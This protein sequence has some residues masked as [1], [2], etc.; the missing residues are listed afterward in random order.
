M[1]CERMRASLLAVCGIAAFQLVNG[2]GSAATD[3]IGRCK[4]VKKAKYVAAA[5]DTDGK[6]WTFNLLP[7]KIDV[8]CNSSSEQGSVSIS[9]VIR[10]SLGAAKAGLVVR[11]QLAGESKSLWV[12]KALSDINTDACGVASFT[13]NWVCPSSNKEVS[14][15][16]NSDSG[17]LTSNSIQVTIANLVIV[18]AKSASGAGAPAAGAP[19]AGAPAA[20]A[21]AAGAP[22]APAAP[23]AK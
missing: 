18:D 21:P 17:P 14:G 12:N 9:G 10:D 13:L 4:A 5:T 22:A 15:T 19:A 16:F 23:A 1:G 8:R 3:E 7:D 11:P 6:K 20:G 2:C